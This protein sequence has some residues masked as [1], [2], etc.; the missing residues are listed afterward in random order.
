MKPASALSGCVSLSCV[1]GVGG[2]QAS[3]SIVLFLP[4][5]F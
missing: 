1:V 3:Y 5:S 4:T 2:G